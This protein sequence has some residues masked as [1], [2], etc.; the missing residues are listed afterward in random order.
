AA[1]AMGREDWAQQW[2]Q[3]AAQYDTVFYGQMAGLQLG[4]MPVGTLEATAVVTPDQ[5]EAFRASDLVRVT[6]A[7]AALEREDLLPFFFAALRSN[8]TSAAD[9]KQVGLLA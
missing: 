5:Q 3:V 6:R 1:R 4:S 7:L 8:A 2:F 9:Y